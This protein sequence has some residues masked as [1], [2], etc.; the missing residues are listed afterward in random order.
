ME[1]PF[2]DRQEAGRFLAS[3]LKKYEAKKDTVVLG[4]PRGGV[5][6][7]YEVAQALGLPMDVFVVRKLGLPGQEELAMG[8]IA[9]GGACVINEEVVR[10]SGLSDEDIDRV[11]QRESAELDRRERLYR[12]G[13]PLK[14]EGKT[15]ILVDDGLA[16]GST[17]SAAVFA[18]KKRGVRKLVVAVP[19]GAPDTCEAFK[20]EVDEAICAVMPEPF[21][22]V[23]V[24]YEDFRPTTDDEVRDLLHRGQLHA[25][26]T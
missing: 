2:S 21:H 9:T 3:K 6:V 12:E 22:A 10:E 26:R 8:A 14:L 20:T 18:L 7:A 13:P 15:V 16:T 19:V 4:L 5:P 23:G 17:M 25:G 24:W 11:V 1:R